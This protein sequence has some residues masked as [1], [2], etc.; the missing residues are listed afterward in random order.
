MHEPNK[1]S[2]NL[3]FIE[4]LSDFVKKNQF[5]YKNPKSDKEVNNI[6][7]VVGEH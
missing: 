4:L 3:D 7:V 2:T 6:P 5:K 1:Y